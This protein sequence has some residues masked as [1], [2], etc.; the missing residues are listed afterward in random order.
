MRGLREGDECGCRVCE[1]GDVCDWCVYDDGMAAAYGVDIVAT[2]IG[3]GA[4]EE[5]VYED[6][7]TEEYGGGEADNV[8]GVKVGA[9]TDGRGGGNGE[10]GDCFNTGDELD[11]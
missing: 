9:G 5:F 3:G 4:C 2:V 10:L 8:E 1:G 11:W 6:V 7:M